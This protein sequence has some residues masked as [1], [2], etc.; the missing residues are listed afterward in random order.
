MAF[1]APRAAPDFR[2]AAP[3]AAAAA[4][5]F[6]PLQPRKRRKT[7][8]H[9]VGK[10]ISRLALSSPAN[11]RPVVFY[12]TGSDVRCASPLPLRVGPPCA[13]VRM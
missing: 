13:N 11:M 1:Q 3:A 7:L 10:K 6:R 8:R 12:G 5:A 2:H 4:G 9:F